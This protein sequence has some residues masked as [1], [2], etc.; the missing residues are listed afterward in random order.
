MVA[1]FGYQSQLG[2]SANNPVDQRFDFD[3]EEVVLDEEFLD[4]NGLRGTR[5]RS[6]ERIRQG[7]RRVHGMIRLQPTATELEA[8]LPWILGGTPTGT[9]T[10]TYPLADALTTRFVAIDRGSHVF[11]YNGCVVDTCTFHAAQNQPLNVDLEIIGIDETLGASGSFPSLNLD[12][13]TAPFIFTDLAL[14]VAST[15]YNTRQFELKIDNDIEKERFFNSQT[16]TAGYPK[17][18]HITLSHPLPYGDDAAAYN[19]GVAGVAATLTFT[20]GA[21]VLEFSLSNCKYPRH[22]P[23]VEGHEE[24]FLPLTATAYATGSPISTR[25]LVTTLKT[26]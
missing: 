6:E 13:A 8:L 19:L 3:S 15:T 4:T 7:I 2:V 9:G 21:Q 25:E 12:V 16:L 18:R 23:R 10:I 5:S 17:D 11:T 22:S 1:T 24:I 14:V 20:F 26:S